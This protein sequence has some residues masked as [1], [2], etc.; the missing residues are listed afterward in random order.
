M[1]LII[2][3]SKQE[4]IAVTIHLTSELLHEIKAYYQYTG[5]PINEK[6]DGFFEQ[7][8]LYIFKKDKD[9]K[10]WKKMNSKNQR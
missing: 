6:L 9:F 8:A 7:A 5:L 3:E 4:K 10:K 2:P 1:P